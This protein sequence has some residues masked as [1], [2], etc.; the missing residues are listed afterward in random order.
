MPTDVCFNKRT[1][2]NDANIVV[3]AMRQHML[4]KTGANALSFQF[5]RNK[6]VV[7]GP[8]GRLNRAVIE[9]RFVAVHLKFETSFLLVMRDFLRFHNVFFSETTF[10]GVMFKDLF[11]WGKGCSANHAM[12]RMV[13]PVLILLLLVW[14]GS[15]INERDAEEE[16]LPEREKEEVVD[17]LPAQP[18]IR[19]D[20]EEG[21]P[22]YTDT[23]VFQLVPED[24]VLQDVHELRQHFE[25]ILDF[26]GDFE[27]YEGK[28]DDYPYCPEWGLSLWNGQENIRLHE[29]IV[30]SSWNT[31][32][33]FR[34]I[35]GGWQISRIHLSQR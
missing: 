30:L 5:S 1:L 31:T 2:G 24:V 9:H 22:V 28:I 17:S 32:V 4:D 15:R 27:V 26:M 34:E 35:E 23:L 19:Q 10:A 33:T 25:K 14:N 3:A 16:S 29:R 20:I 12:K 11:G 7:Q 13:I 8:N 21:V 6:C 18:P